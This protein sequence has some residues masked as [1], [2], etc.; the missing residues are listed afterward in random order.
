MDN[1]VSE[2]ISLY[3]KTTLIYVNFI[4]IWWQNKYI[5]CLFEVNVLSS[6]IKI[7][8]INVMPFSIRVLQDL[9]CFW[10]HNIT[11]II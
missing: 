8:F 10:P 3:Y 7:D 9:F 4:V 2:L 1:V 11:A 5:R 6:G